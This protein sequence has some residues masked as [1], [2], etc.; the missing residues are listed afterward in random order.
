VDL[1]VFEIR[2]QSEQVAD[3][4]QELVVNAV[5]DTDV[6]PI[7]RDQKVVGAKAIIE[8]TD[9]L[10]PAIQAAYDWLNFKAWPI[11]PEDFADFVSSLNA[12]AARVQVP[13][14]TGME[15][16]FS[17]FSRAHARAREAARPRPPSRAAVI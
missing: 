10:P 14:R 7:D 17:W 8:T 1:A 16:Y 11:K 12:G 6:V 15:E 3:P 2:A 5:V 13:I 4:N 9:D